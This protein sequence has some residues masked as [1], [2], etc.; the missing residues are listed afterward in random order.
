MR[1]HLAEFV[2]DG[3]TAL[4]FTGPKGGAIR[5]GNF[6]NLTAWTK[7]VAELGL[8]GLHFHDLRHGQ[9]AGGDERRDPGPDGPHGHDSM[10]AAIIYQ[11]ATTEADASIAA[12]LEAA[13]DA[14]DRPA[15][16]DEDQRDDDDGAPGALVPAR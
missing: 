14:Q 4:V 2:P 6:R 3:L 13:I 7:T 12:S 11:H 9:H 1:G 10:R 16:D 8:A 5:W 15:A